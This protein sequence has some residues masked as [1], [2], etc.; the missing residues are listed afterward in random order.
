M[1]KRLARSN[2]WLPTITRSPTSH[3]ALGLA[4]TGTISSDPPRVPPAPSAGTTKRGTAGSVARQGRAQ[5]GQRDPARVG[6]LAHPV[7]RRVQAALAE[8]GSKPGS[9]RGPRA[10]APPRTRPGLGVALGAIVKS[11]LFADDGAPVMA[12]VAGDR[13]CDTQALPGAF[14]RT[15]GAARGR[16]AV[17]EATGFAFGGVPPLGHAGPLPVRSTPASA[18]SSWSSPPPATPI[19][20]FRPACSSSAC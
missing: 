10:R 8:K 7:V 17:R 1:D 9:W 15:A 2:T 14:G 13:R 5:G 18:A 4:S 6:R 3:L 19:A 12:L 20:C 11:L 16:R